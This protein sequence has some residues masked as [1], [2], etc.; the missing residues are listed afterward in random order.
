MI[1]ISWSRELGKLILQKYLQPLTIF[2]KRFIVEVWQGSEH[3]SDAS[4]LNI[5]EFWIY[6][7]S[8]YPRI[9]NML[10]VLN[11]S[12]LLIYH[13]SEYTR[14]TQGFEYDWIDLN[15]SWVC[16]ILPECTQIRMNSVCFTFTHCNSLS[17][18][19]ID[20]FLGK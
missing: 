11:I 16:L 5:R 10:L 12:G 15:N 6:Q 4:F 3:A 13:G 20:C 2:A 17:E 14:V 1:F 9:L 18:G 7:S 8:E 19:T